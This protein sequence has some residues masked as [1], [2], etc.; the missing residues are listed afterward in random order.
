[1]GSSSLSGYLP[2]TQLD[3]LSLQV[4]SRSPDSPA[5]S[6]VCG[7]RVAVPGTPFTLH[8]PCPLAEPALPASSQ[9]CHL[10]WAP[11]LV[12]ISTSVCDGRL[13][14]APGPEPWG[15][16]KF[17]FSVSPVPSTI[18]GGKEGVWGEGWEVRGDDNL[19]RPRVSPGPLSPG[20]TGEERLRVIGGVGPVAGRSHRNEIARPCRFFSCKS[21]NFM[22]Q[23]TTK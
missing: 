19:A 14:T 23:G 9:C 18:P 15:R 13:I 16:A 4:V 11:V 22:L 2:P 3:F 17:S 20:L 6:V 7:V 8:P 5:I 21:C 10:V 1:M 12:S